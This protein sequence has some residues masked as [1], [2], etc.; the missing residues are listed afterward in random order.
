MRCS[1]AL[2]DT[3]FKFTSNL[4]GITNTE[5]EFYYVSQQLPELLSSQKREKEER[6]RTIRKA[7]KLIP[8][9][10]KERRVDVKIQNNTLYINKV[11]Q[12]QHIYPPTVQDVLNLP[13][14]EQEKIND[15]TF[16]HSE[17][18]SDKGSNF[19]GHAL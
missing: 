14:P 10:E 12:K 6:L 13:V 18:I 5:G 7:N 2:R 1:Q 3:V 4:K 16:Q 19:K 9:D 15:I 8:E 17:V 11:P